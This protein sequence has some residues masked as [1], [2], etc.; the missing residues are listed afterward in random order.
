MRHLAYCVAAAAIGFPLGYWLTWVCHEA[1]EMLD[2]YL[3]GKVFDV[4]SFH[5]EGRR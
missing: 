5:P 3:D 4:L 2:A 1:N